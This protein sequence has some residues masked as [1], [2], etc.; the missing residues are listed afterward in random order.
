M[1]PLNARSS[2]SEWHA[3]VEISSWNHLLPIVSN[4]QAKIGNYAGPIEFDENVS[5]FDVPMSNG[6]LPT[7]SM[8]LC[9][10]VADPTKRRMTY[11][12]LK[13]GQKTN[14]HNHF[15]PRKRNPLPFVRRLACFGPRSHRGIRSR[16]NRWWGA[17]GSIHPFLW[18][19][20]QWN[21]GY[22]RGA[23]E[24]SDKSQSL[25]TKRPHP[26]WKIPID[27][28]IV[29]DKWIAYQVNGLNCSAFIFGLFVDLERGQL[30]QKYVK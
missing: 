12:K 20:Q 3:T 18:C 6:R 29:N 2:A 13:P 30:L 4:G 10:K 5:R 1:F 23:S 9:V 27:G 22:F 15:F 14:F 21:P 25:E 16:S 26:L 11:P 7:G 19:R 24:Q 17:F 28:V 8:D